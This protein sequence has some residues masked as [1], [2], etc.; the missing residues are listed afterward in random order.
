MTRIVFVGGDGS[1]R[2]NELMYELQ[3][4]TAIA[5]I[6]LNFALFETLFKW[7]SKKILS[8]DTTKHK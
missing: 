3:D 2:Q 1:G 8:N 4:V 6:H 7:T 5:M